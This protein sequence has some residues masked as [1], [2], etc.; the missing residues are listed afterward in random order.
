MET[1][2]PAQAKIIKLYKTPIARPVQP[3]RLV[4][5]ELAESFRDAIYEFQK[6]K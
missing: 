6:K 3:I 5:P 4:E 2:K 1:Q